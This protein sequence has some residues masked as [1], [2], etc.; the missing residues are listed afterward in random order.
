MTAN[1]DGLEFAICTEVRFL[2]ERHGANAVRAM[3]TMLYDI[4]IHRW[5]L[6]ERCNCDVGDN[7][8]ISDWNARYG[9]I[10]TEEFFKIEKDYKK[11]VYSTVE[12]KLYCFARKNR[13]KIIAEQEKMRNSKSSSMRRYSENPVYALDRLLLKHKS[14]DIKTE[15][16]LQL[17]EIRKEAWYQ[18][19]LDHDLVA[20]DWARIYGTKW[21]DHYVNVLCFIVRV[22][23]DQFRKIIEEGAKS[24]G[25]P[26]A[27]R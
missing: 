6:S 4:K 19:N 23:E 25:F 5:C 27:A 15:I 24:N 21:R 20:I 1:Y 14:I 7:A 9:W 2:I 18:G 26:A 17:D 16:S 12:K 3:R 11:G 8:A 22:K 13:D 10:M